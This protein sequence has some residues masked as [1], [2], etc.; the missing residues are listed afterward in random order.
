MTWAQFFEWLA[1]C[2]FKYTRGDM[3]YAGSGYWFPQVPDV[4]HG[5]E[6]PLPPEP[7][8]HVEKERE[9]TGVFIEASFGAGAFTHDPKEAE[10]NA[11]RLLIAF[12]EQMGADPLP[13]MAAPRS[14]PEQLGPTGK[15]QRV[16]EAYHER[17]EREWRERNAGLL[18]HRSASST[19]PLI[20]PYDK[21]RNDMGRYRGME[22][23]RAAAIQAGL[24]PV[25]RATEP[26][27]HF[28]GGWTCE[29]CGA[30]NE[31]K[32]K[33]CRA[34]SSAKGTPMPPVAY[35]APRFTNDPADYHRRLE[36]EW[37]T[38]RPV[39]TQSAGEDFSYGPALE[40]PEE[41]YERRQA[42]VREE[43]ERYLQEIGPKKFD[44]VSNSCD[45]G[46]HERCRDDDC[47]CGCHPT[48]CACGAVYTMEQWLELPFI[49]EQELEATS[50]EPAEVWTARNCVCG[51]TMMRRE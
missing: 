3:H 51:S 27:P 13:P 20:V 34:C 48:V 25:R 28:P 19:E 38:E 36:R 21:K 29:V 32:S 4:S 6:A 7:W 12:D 11:T 16:S 14:A 18:K 46:A 31:K 35:V 41:A 8:I 40:T 45:M 2:G 37:A 26:E 10:Q 42:R 24:N 43:E 1:T 44:G 50:D 9:G 39:Q 5:E 22:E 15:S 30:G 23:D 33:A 49:G 17:M 47:E